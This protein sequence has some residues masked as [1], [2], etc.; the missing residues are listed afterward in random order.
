MPEINPIGLTS[1]HRIFHLFS[2]RKIN[3]CFSDVR[4]REDLIKLQKQRNSIHTLDDIRDSLEDACAQ[5]KSR[6]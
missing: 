3:L 1:N 4:N 5:I 6:F 2:Y